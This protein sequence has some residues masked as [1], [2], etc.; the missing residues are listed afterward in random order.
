MA[1]PKNQTNVALSPSKR[2][3]AIHHVQKQKSFLFMLF[4]FL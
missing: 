2:P 1:L 4:M 3:G